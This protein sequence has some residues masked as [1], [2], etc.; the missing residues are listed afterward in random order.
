MDQHA[1]CWGFGGSA[2]C[3]AERQCSACDPA[4]APP[5]QSAICLFSDDSDEPSSTHAAILHEFDPSDTCWGFGGSSRCAAGMQCDACEFDPSDTCWGIAPAL[6]TNTHMDID[7]NGTDAAAND[8][9][10]LTQPDSLDSV[11]CDMATDAPSDSAPAPASEAAADLVPDPSIDVHNNANHTTADTV[12]AWWNQADPFPDRDILKLYRGPALG[13][14]CQSDESDSDL[15]PDETPDHLTTFEE[16]MPIYDPS[17][18][19]WRNHSGA[20]NIVVPELT[21]VLADELYSTLNKC[22]DRQPRVDLDTPLPMTD[23]R[24]RHADGR[25]DPALL[26]DKFTFSIEHGPFVAQFLRG[27]ATT[28]E[29]TGLEIWERIQQWFKTATN[30]IHRACGRTLGGSRRGTKSNHSPRAQLWAIPRE[31]FCAEARPYVWDLRSFQQDAEAGIHPIRAGDERRESGLGNATHKAH[32]A[33][34]QQRFQCPDAETPNRMVS[35]VCT[36]SDDA[37]DGILLGPN[38]KGFYDE[39]DFAVTKNI[40]ELAEGVLQGTFAGPCFLPCRVFPNNVAIQPNGKKRRTGDGGWPRDFTLLGADLSLN[41]AIDIDNEDQFPAYTLPS[42]VTFAR[43]LAIASTCYEMTGDPTM[44]MHVLLSDWVAYYRTFVLDIRY[45]WTQLNVYMPT[46]CTVDTA[47]YFGDK[48]APNFSNHAMNWLLFMWKNLFRELIQSKTSWDVQTRKAVPAVGAW[49]TH[50]GVRRW[51]QNRYDLALAAGHSADE[52][53][54]QSI[55]V[56]FQGYFDDGQTATAAALLPDLVTAL[57]QLVNKVG[58]AVEYSKLV[59]ATPDGKLGHCQPIGDATPQSFDDVDFS[60]SMGSPVV[61]GKEIDLVGR[62]VQETRQR[63]VDMVQRLA[64]TCSRDFVWTSNMRSLIGQLMFIVITIA[65]LRGTLN[66]PI[67]CLKAVTRLDAVR[68]RSMSGRPGPD[69]ERQIDH[70]VP[71]GRT[72]KQSLAMAAQLV[73]HQ[74]GRQFAPQWAVPLRDNTIYIM[75]DAAGFAGFFDTAFRGGASWVIIPGLS[76]TLWCVQHWPLGLLAI[77][78]ST[79][80]EVINAN[81]T[82]EAILAAYPSHDV[83]EVLDNQAAVACLKRCA[84]DSKTLIDQMAFRQSL[85]TRLQGSRRIFTQWSRRELGTLA[86]M[87]SKGHIARFCAGLLARHLPPAALTQMTRRS[88]D[89]FTE[90]S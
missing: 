20:S 37:F 76:I 19:E 39:V 55:P 70:L 72:A 23:W 67:R 73:I 41:A 17:D 34:L 83:C 79:E 87:L 82:L 53:Y 66:A 26:F 32:I 4:G 36:F 28:I 71:L 50:A 86:D 10:M 33:A 16:E 49:D 64:E 30:D 88:F 59:W 63:Q 43:A 81:Y 47:L 8:E 5:V 65:E 18:S 74:R 11:N 15:D 78:H 27:G 31:A 80:L 38:Y 56:V 6:C 54:F 75:N 46:G 77:A 42:A 45:F 51:R 14:L 48:G 22:V 24:P 69:G 7:P 21:H 89:S 35:G 61:L 3:T 60:F 44:Q 29:M 25:W 40:K 13:A 12:T 2:R 58:V 1:L 84:C 62:L 52:A 90:L 9:V 85:I 68:R 57:F